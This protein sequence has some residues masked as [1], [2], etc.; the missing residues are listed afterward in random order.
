M[1]GAFCNPGE[2]GIDVANCDDDDDRR[3][4]SVQR[5]LRI[6]RIIRRVL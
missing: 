6:M 3:L 1:Y 4:R 5:S 2:G